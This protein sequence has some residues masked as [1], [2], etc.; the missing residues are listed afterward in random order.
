MKHKILV[1]V[2]V[3]CC[4][5]LLVGCGTS[6]KT[7]RE[8]VREDPEA[9]SGIREEDVVCKDYTVKYNGGMYD[10]INATRYAKGMIEDPNRF[11]DYHYVIVDN[12]SGW[13]YMFESYHEMVSWAENS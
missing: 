8:V 4:I 7:L 11:C 13:I 10:D 9:L 6:G 12:S 2:T 5:V 1:A 3:L